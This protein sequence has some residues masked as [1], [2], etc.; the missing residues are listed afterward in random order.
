MQAGA[1]LTAGAQTKARSC[2]KRKQRA[3]SIR[4]AA[5]PH[6]AQT[7]PRLSPQ[8]TPRTLGPQHRTPRAARRAVPNTSAARREAPNATAACGAAANAMDSRRVQRR[9]SCCYAT[10]FTFVPR[11]SEPNSASTL[12][13]WA[14]ATWVSIVL[15]ELAAANE[16]MAPPESAEAPVS[17]ML[18][19]MALISVQTLLFFTSGRAGFPTT[20]SPSPTSRI[21]TA[22]APV[23]APAPIRTGATSEEFDP[24]KA[25]GPISV[26]CL[27]LP[28]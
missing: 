16:A 21:T 5:R 27:C 20:R 2:A 12:A 26:R 4:A 23:C 24:T 22:P 19:P 15:A 28:S 6:A 8:R 9:E 25:P 11:P 1:M 18:I 10:A 7:P 13:T 3:T 17:P 14:F